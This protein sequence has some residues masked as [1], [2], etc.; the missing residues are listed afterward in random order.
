MTDSAPTAVPSKARVFVRRAGSTLML[1]GMVGVTFASMQSWAY[2]G[3]L[4]LLT[5]V[6]TRE[7]Y[8]MLRVA[9][10]RSFP[11][12]GLALA[13]GYSGVLYAGLL[14]DS[15]GIFATWDLFAVC[16]AIIGAF[17]LEMR[18]PIRLADS[19]VAVTLTL[20]GFIYIA[21]LFNFA[22][23]L[24]FLAPGWQV[25][26]GRV[27]QPAAVLLLWLLA[28]TKFTDMGAYIVGSLIGRHKLI[29]HVSPGKTWEGLGG[30]LVFSQLAG[31][32]LYAA[33]PQELAVLGGWGHVIFLGLLLSALAVLGDLAESVVKRALQAK[34]SGRMLPGIGGALDL[35]DSI[36][37]TAPALYFYL[38]WVLLPA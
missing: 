28:V 21:F 26:T 5:V 24:L 31:C 22:A 6:A 37:F 11:R 10:L 7:Y 29:P 13:V 25:G 36:C 4:G 34:D 32:G 20:C 15:G 12:F 23:K 27:A 33:L 38:Q 16:L 19:L 9:G 3:L 1:W 8:Q 17:I 30:A 35:I 18:G 14:R 2:L